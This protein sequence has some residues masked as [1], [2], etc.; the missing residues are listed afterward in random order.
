[1]IFMEKLL[2]GIQ[3]LLPHRLLSRLMHAFM[4]MRFSPIKNLQIWIVGGLAGVNWE[5]ALSD[6]AAD[7]TTF[8]DF[9]TR[10]LKPGSRVQDPDPFSFTCPADGRISQCGR[11]TNDRLFQA[12]G[13]HYSL[14]SLLGND[15]AYTE[16]SNGFFHTVYLSPK[17]Y[18]RVHMPMDG[19][20]IRMIHVPGRLFS[21]ASYTV[22]Q[23]PNLFARNE[24]VICL[25]E[26]THGPMAVILVGAMLV[27]SMATVWAGTI[28]P[29]YG[30]RITT[31]D[32][33]RRDIV[34]KKGDE[35]GRFNMGST[36][37]VLLPAIAV[38]SLAELGPDDEVQVGVK[39]GRL[40]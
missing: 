36:V 27:S 4:R 18:H 34:L 21:V 20:L 25:F 40:R 7:Y 31:G 8:N 15:P 12:K 16:F 5:E 10:E 26:T 38:S 30:R 6:D 22:R 28:T 29:P 14:R 37:I 32:W 3:Y 11:I 9:F 33:S 24:R 19:K 13:H 23:V 2:C 17:D 35:L 39:L 1:M